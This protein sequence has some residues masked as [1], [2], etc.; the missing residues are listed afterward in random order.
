MKLNILA[1]GDIRHA[2][3]VTL[4]QIRDHAQLIRANQAVRKANAHHEIFRRFAFT[5][6]PANG[7]HAVALRVNAP[8]FEI[9][10]GPFGQ[11][12]TTSLARKFA[13]FLER[14]P[15]VLFEL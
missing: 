9:E 14:F 4:R 8:P 13:N 6:L 5:A 1:N 2:A 10:V 12:G 15:R 11:H 7:A 3:R